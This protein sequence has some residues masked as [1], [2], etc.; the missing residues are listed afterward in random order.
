MSLRIIKSGVL[1]SVQDMGRHGWQHLGINPAGV[2]DQFSARIAN[3]LVGNDPEEATIELHFP[4]SIFL[5]EQPALIAISGADFSASINGEPVPSSHAFIVNKNSLL[6]FQEPFRGARAYL[7]VKG[8]IKADEWLGS[9]STHLRAMIGGF[10]GRSLQKND[11]VFFRENSD[12]SSAL[13]QKE[14]M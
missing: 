2:M 1:D 6:L 7:A 4:A 10:R 13:G 12:Y 8:G 5:F 3:M 11:Q 9:C 14:F